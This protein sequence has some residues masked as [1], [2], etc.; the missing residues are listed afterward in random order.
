MTYI[1]CRRHYE[2]SFIF[3]ISLKFAANGD[4]GIIYLYSNF[5]LGTEFIMLRWAFLLQIYI[6]N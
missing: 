6:L 1:F 4:S 2:I 5:L 3:V